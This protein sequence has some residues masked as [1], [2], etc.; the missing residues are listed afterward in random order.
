[1]SLWAMGIPA[2]CTGS[3]HVSDVQARIIRDYCNEVVIMQDIGT[4]GSHGT[5]GFYGEDEEYHPG[6]VDKLEPFIRVR[7]APKHF[8]DPNAY[9]RRGNTRRVQQL[10]KDARPSFVARRDIAVL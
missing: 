1:M 5:W 4:A 7:V 3:T 9:F 10:V 2:I 6:A 8:L